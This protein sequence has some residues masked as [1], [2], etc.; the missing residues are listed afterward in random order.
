MPRHAKAIVD[1]AGFFT[2]VRGAVFGGRLKQGQVDGMD[3]I[4]GAWDA[5]AFTDR[6]W[7]AYMLGTA[8]HETAFT[9]QPI[10]EYGTAAYFRRMYDITGD[11]PKLATQLGNTTPGDGAKYCGRGFVQLTGKSNYQRASALLGVD[12][13]GT[14]DLAMDRDIAAKIMFEGMTVADIVFGDNKST[15]PDY[16]FTGKSLESYFNDTVEDWVE[17]RRIIN[18]TDHAEMIA[19]TARKF[20]DAISY[21]AVPQDDAAA[22]GWDRVREIA[23]RLGAADYPLETARRDLLASIPA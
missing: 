20:L 7:L 8:Y 14:P 11:R 2:T 22:S 5:S 18:G 6:R 17:A 9:M 19:A 10:K 13:V 16:T 1:R 3:C 4:L 23:D 21:L 12:L 15:D